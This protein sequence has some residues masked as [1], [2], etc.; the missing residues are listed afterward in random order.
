MLTG[1]LYLRA[2]RQNLGPPRAV[3]WSV[4]FAVRPL[5]LPTTTVAPAMAV[6]TVPVRGTVTHPATKCR[7][8]RPI[9]G[10]WTIYHRRRRVVHRSWLVV[11]RWWRSI[12]RLRRV[13]VAW[14]VT[15]HHLRGRQVHAHG[16][17]DVTVGHGGNTTQTQSCRNNH[18]TKQ[19]AHLSLLMNPNRNKRSGASSTPRPPHLVDNLRQ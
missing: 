17:S 3:G 14:A 5:A 10:R 13:V 6:S 19:F 16:P 2:A 12:H 7:G 8:R 11:D 15:N 4:G 9:D 18:T 1:F